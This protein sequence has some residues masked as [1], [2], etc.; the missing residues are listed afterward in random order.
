MV[1]I[2]ETQEVLSCVVITLPRGSMVLHSV[3]ITA[4]YIPHQ[5]V[6]LPGGVSARDLA[7]GTF[8][9]GTSAGL[10][11]CGALRLC[12]SSGVAA[13]CIILCNCASYV[14][15]VTLVPSYR[16]SSAVLLTGLGFPDA[17]LL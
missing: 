13:L 6:S 3:S 1:S 17:V 8:C 14:L 15:S 7:S 12:N 11:S 4:S 9:F 5:V 16:R 10:F 2:F